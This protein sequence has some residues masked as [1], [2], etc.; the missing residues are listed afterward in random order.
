VLHPSS[1]R[2]NVWPPSNRKNFILQV[3]V[4]WDVILYSD[5]VED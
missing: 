3:V 1:G 4:F 2:S 5:V